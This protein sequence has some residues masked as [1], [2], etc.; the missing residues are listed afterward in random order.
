VDLLTAVRVRAPVAVLRV[1]YAR[2][3]ERLDG[4]IARLEKKL[5]NEQFVGKAQPEVVTKEREK[6]A[7]Y[8]AARTR[9]CERLVEIATEGTDSYEQR[10]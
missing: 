8:Q 9:V 5:A 7:G 3:R 2:E 4:E 6:L 10:S 1:R